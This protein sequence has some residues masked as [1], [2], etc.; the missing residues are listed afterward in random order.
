MD[1]EKIIKSR[2]VRATF[3]D[4][5]RFIIDLMMLRIQYKIKTGRKLNLYNPK[6]F[7]EKL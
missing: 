7:T 2:A 6:R 5:L 3:L 1:H 4:V